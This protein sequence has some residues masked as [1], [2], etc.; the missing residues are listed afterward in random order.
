MYIPIILISLP[1]LG[2]FAECNTPGYVPCPPSSFQ[3][4]ASG[5]T[6]PPAVLGGGINI[7]TPAGS[8]PVVD[9]GGDEIQA[10]PP[11]VKRDGLFVRQNALCCKPA[12]VEC[13]IWTEYNVPF[14]YVSR[15]F[16]PALARYPPLENGRSE[17]VSTELRTDVMLL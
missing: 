16:S 5:S 15:L 8:N 9:A 3:G 17:M 13:R 11:S 10:P 7:P 6:L 1:I 4:S 14:C 2:V 12:P